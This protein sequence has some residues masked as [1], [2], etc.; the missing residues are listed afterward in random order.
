MPRDNIKILK[1]GLAIPNDVSDYAAFKER[2]I[3]SEEIFKNSVFGE[4]GL[5]SGI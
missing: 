5:Q 2:I 4:I 3:K 1:F